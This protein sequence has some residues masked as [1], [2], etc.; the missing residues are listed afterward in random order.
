MDNIAW[1]VDKKCSRPRRAC[2]ITLNFFNLSHS[3]IIYLFRFKMNDFYTCR[4]SSWTCDLY[5][6]R[7][8]YVGYRY[9]PSF[10]FRTFSWMVKIPKWLVHCFVRWKHTY[11]S[12]VFLVLALFSRSATW[13]VNEMKIYSCACSNA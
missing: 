6:K 3:C 2:S 7:I 11:F 1:K 13:T 12:R 10:I 5:A 4:P 8:G 9:L